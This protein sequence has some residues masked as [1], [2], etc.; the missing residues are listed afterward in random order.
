MLKLNVRTSASAD[1]AEVLAYHAD[2]SPELPE[3]FL[4]QLEAAL[5]LLRERPHVGS[6]CF[7]HLFPDVP[8]RTWSL[9]RFPFRLFYMVDGDT[10]HVLRVDH[11]RRNVTSGTFALS[12]HKQQE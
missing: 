9:D 11:E 7:A 6:R 12:V 5:T 1:L 3:A 10:L 8:L 4:Q 2:I